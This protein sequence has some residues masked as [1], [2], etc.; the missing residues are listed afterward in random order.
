MSAKKR[1][2]NRPQSSRPAAV[3]E[4]RAAEA[5]TVAWMLCFL[6]TVLA[7]ALGLL[8]RMA[9]AF[10]VEMAAIRVLSITLLLVALL[11]GLVTLVLTPVAI[12]LRRHAPPRPVI[13]MACVTG[14]LPLLTLVLLS[15]RGG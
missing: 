5:V 2:K 1:R 12:K 13:I 15:L 10:G 4:S 7:E 14:I 3:P 11:S 9:M 6:A 8:T